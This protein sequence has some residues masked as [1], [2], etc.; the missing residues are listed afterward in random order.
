M[1]VVMQERATEEQIEKVVAHLVELGVQ[2]LDP[3]LGLPWDRWCADGG[4]GR[5]SNPGCVPLRAARDRGGS[6]LVVRAED[7]ERP[8]DEALD[9]VRRGGPMTHP[10]P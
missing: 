8:C 2:P 3:E 10:W 1:V 4:L 7:R 9:R 5:G 6:G